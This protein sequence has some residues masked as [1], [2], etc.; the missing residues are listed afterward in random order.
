VHHPGIAGNRWADAAARYLRRGAPA[1]F[2]FDLVA[3]GDPEADRIRVH[4]VVDG[5]RLIKLVANIGDVRSLVAHPAS[6]T[7]SHLDDTQLAEAGI[8]RTTIRLS[9]GLE[10]PADLLADLAQALDAA[11][12]IP[13]GAA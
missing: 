12:A 8:S 3:T 7:H 2:S 9:V 13:E 6:M 4:R 10:D 11:G 1:V 5:L